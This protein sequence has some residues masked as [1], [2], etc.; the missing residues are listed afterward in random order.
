MANLN[1]FQRF[2]QALAQA[3]SQ[4][5]RAM[6][7]T[8]AAD[9]DG[10]IG[11]ITRGKAGQPFKQIVGNV[12]EHLFYIRL[13]GQ[14]VCNGLVQARLFAQL[15]F[16]IGVGQAAY[17]K[18]QV[19]IDRHAALKT[20]RLHQKSGAGFRLVQKAQFDGIAQLLQVQIGGVN[21][22]VSKVDDGPQQLGLISNGFGQ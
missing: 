9:A 16:P 1:V 5:H 2:L 6:M 3:L 11:P 10:D 22:Q 12:L 14:V 21:G 18:H 13:C 7:P 17:I 8:C 4:V 20:K 15:G 19:S